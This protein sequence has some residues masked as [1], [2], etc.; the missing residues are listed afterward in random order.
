[1]INEAKQHLTGTI[2]PFWKNLRDDEYGG[3]S[4]YVGFDLKTDKKAV[5]GCILNSRILWFFSQAY[6]LLKDESLLEEARH[7][8]A[9]LIHNFTDKK[10]GGVYWSVNFDGTPAD[11]AKHTYCQ[12]FA[13]YGLAAYYMASK[14][15]KALDEALALFDIIESRCT[16]EKGYLESL[17]RQFGQTENDKLSENGV[18]ASKTMNTLLHVF[19]A[20]AELYIACRKPGVKKRLLHILDIFADKI[21]N[22]KLQRQEVFFDGNYNSLIDMQSYGHDIETSWLIDRGTAIAGEKAYVEKMAPITSAL[23]EKVYKKAYDGRSIDN[24]CVRGVTDTARVWWVQAEA[25]NGFL[26]AYMKNNEK[27]EYLHAAENIFDFIREYVADKR[28]GSEWFWRVDREGRPD[29]AKPIVEPWKCPY[30]NGR[31]CMEIIRSNV[32]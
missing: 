5:K 32:G 29:T 22:P 1:M 4:G 3:Y 27:V 9:F 23:A 8:Y 6:M 31:M 11:T 12:A 17:D 28:K 14:D 16:D 10:Y 20:Y 30:H 26:N 13:V 19:E 24:E 25:V 2:I 21:Y 15:E 7:A 18:M